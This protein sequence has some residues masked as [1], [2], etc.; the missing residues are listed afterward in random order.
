MSIEIIVAASGVAVSLVSAFISSYLKKHSDKERSELSDD[1]K[2]TITEIGLSVA[3]I[4]IM[5]SVK[6]EPQQSNV[7]ITDEL[8][9]KI[10]EGI[11]SKISSQGEISHDDVKAEVGRA[12]QEINSRLEKIEARFPDK[13][14][15]DKIASINDALFAERLEQLSSRITEMEKKQL[16]KWDVALVVS[17]IVA[18]IFTVVGT[19]YAVLKAVGVV[20]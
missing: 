18:A 10:E 14:S 17:M 19:T 12:V 16:S 9:A 13:S 5:H 6:S 11:V 7:E 20:S 8:L 1:V 3:G 15:I 4:E 2:R